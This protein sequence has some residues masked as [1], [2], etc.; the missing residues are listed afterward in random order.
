MV[1]QVLDVT[2]VSQHWYTD[3]YRSIVWSIGKGVL[4]MLDGF[5]GVINKIWRYEFFDNEYVN[6]IFSGAII[7][8]CSWL[9]LKVVIEL[10]MNY[11]VKSENRGSPLTVYRGIILAIVMMF[12]V[13]SLFQFG[14]NISTTL[15][16]SV[17]SI[18][19]LNTESN[20]ETQISRA[21]VQSM[22]Y[23]DETKESDITYLVDNWRDVGI[24]DTDGGFVG[25]GDKYKYSLNFFMLIVLSLVTVLLLFFVA[26]QMGKRVMEIALFKVIAPFCCTSLTNDGK[27]F[28]TWCKGTVGLFMV[29]VV[30]F[31]SIGLML[32]MFGSAFQENGTLT[33]IFLVIGAL[34]FIIGTPTIINSL[35]G[36]QTG[37]MSG[38]GDMQSLIAIGS[39]TA[40]GIGIAKAGTMGAL[41]VGSYIINKGGNVVSGGVGKISNMLNKSSKITEEQMMNIKE[42]VSNN[43]IYKAQQQLNNFMNSNTKLNNCIDNNSFNSLSKNLYNPMRNQYLNHS[44]LENKNNTL[45]GKSNVSN[46]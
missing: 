23:T 20:A 40:Q 30:Q 27:S 31:V 11:I 26:I 43:N 7:V 3:I 21:I 22:I 25:I 46:T 16:D 42:S 39:T 4:S 29:T 28:E 37:I 33:G 32:K 5:F 34:L 36:H 10:I 12:L 15:T 18:S 17:I 19:G 14:H 2:Q 38:F 6:K 35:L 8:A 41:T 24:N 44:I 9:S 1:V 13:S 45:G